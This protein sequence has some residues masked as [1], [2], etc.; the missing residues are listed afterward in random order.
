MR[1][2]SVK[3]LIKNKLALGWLRDLADAESLQASEAANAKLP[4]KD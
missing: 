2:L 1:Y 3:D 4:R